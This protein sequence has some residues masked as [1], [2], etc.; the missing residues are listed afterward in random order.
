VE[1]INAQ[2][3]AKQKKG[4]KI[5]SHENHIMNLSLKPKSSIM[6][7][8]IKIKKRTNKEITEADPLFFNIDDY[9]VLADPNIL[10]RKKLI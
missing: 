2:I 8:P 10:P 9:K 4:D 3:E 5:V 7:K 6:D 1:A